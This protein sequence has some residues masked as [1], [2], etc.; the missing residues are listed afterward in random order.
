MITITE[1][2][3]GNEVYYI[4][5]VTDDSRIISEQRIHPQSAVVSR[6]GKDY[7]LLYNSDMEVDS[8]AFTYINVSISERSHNTQIKAVE[9]LKFLVA[10]EELV[11][12]PLEV[13]L[14]AD[15]TSLKYFLH[16][17][18]PE[19]QTCTMD[20][21]TVRSNVTVNGYLSVYRGYLQF[22]GIDKHPLF[23]TTAKQSRPFQGADK[24]TMKSQAYRANDRTPKKFVEVPKYISVDEFIKILEYVRAKYDAEVEIIIRLMYQC[25]LRIGEV[26]GLTADDLTMMKTDDLPQRTAYDYK[27]SYVPIAFLRNRVSDTQY[28][29]AKS[30]MKVVSKRQYQTED[31]NTYN[32]GYQFVIVPQD[33][34]DLINE[35]I[36]K[37]H[38]LAR[39]KSHNRYYEKTL[40]DRVRPA[41]DYEDDN[42][43]IFINSKGTPLSASSWNQT[44]R[45]I[46]SA[47][48][49]IV[50][51]NKRK[52]NLNHRFRHGF[53]MFN[54]IYCHTD[55]ATLADLL[56]HRSLGSVMC[57]YNP[58]I[59]DQI[60]LKTA[61]IE[62]MYEAIPA[63]KREDR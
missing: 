47:V 26:L 33:L 5:T 49:I 25:G 44:L 19:G 9:A 8:K 52:N 57:Y 41:E 59:S 23:Q 50:D 51:K 42:Y 32:Y 10:F 16:G 2:K 39:E 4:K 30:C 45:E 63:L 37:Q 58:T 3:L 24:Y 27:S 38:V 20:L 34:F 21:T 28:Q 29:N 61:A 56:R 6:N 12:K 62:S 14:P 43:Y 46:F 1:K 55:A 54:V 17:Y 11:G 40:A 18:A 36:E 60:E 48:G 31:Y 53:A 35:Y 15:I 7:Y 22:L 13:F